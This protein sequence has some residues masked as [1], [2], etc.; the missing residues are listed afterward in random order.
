MID[1]RYKTLH[2]SYSLPGIEE[3]GPFLGCRAVSS[4]NVF[5]IPFHI[6]S[7]IFVQNIWRKF[8]KISSSGF[9]NYSDKKKKTFL[10]TIE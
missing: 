6:L 5:Y 1:T 9:A 2:C 7:I 10:C 8:L 4:H 3:F